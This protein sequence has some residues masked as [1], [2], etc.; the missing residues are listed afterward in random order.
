MHS[1]RELT[2]DVIVIG[3][4]A[5]GSASL[6]HLAKNNLRVLGLDKYHPPHD[7]GSTHGET[8]MIREAYYEDPTYVPLVQ[9]AYRLWDQLENETKQKLFRRTGMIM[10]GGPKSPYMQGIRTS[11]KLHKLPVEEL[12][13]EETMKRY[14]AVN[15]PQGLSAL[16][17]K[18]AGVL[19][20]EKCIEVMLQLA[21]NF[22]AEAKFN[23]ECKKW[24][25][26]AD[27]TFLV[28][29]EKGAYR[30][31]KIV[32][33]AGAWMPGLVPSNLASELK[34]ERKYFIWKKPYG[35]KENLSIN[36]FVCFMMDDPSGNVLYGFPDIGTGVKFGIHRASDGG[37]K[38]K[39]PEEINRT[40]G[41]E[42]AR[43]ALELL[44]KYLPD[45]KD[46]NSK[47]WTMDK[48]ATCM[49]TVTKDYHFV[50]DFL[51]GNK[52]IVVASPCSGHGFK[53][54]I[55]IGEVIKDLLTAG[56]SRFDLSLF[57]LSR[58][59]QKPKL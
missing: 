33:S 35:N 58:F 26:E 19:D 54:A 9:H 44:S 4:G 47:E 48:S 5:M 36:N 2:Y 51:Y 20:P 55:A 39:T 21:R 42:E 23:E 30:A 12:T 46:K 24:T 8:R 13:A 32:L 40:V 7:L 57:R 56:E 6:Y 11:A 53:F 17:E 22:G 45:L 15:V 16:Y 52:N 31:K 38:I 37:E 25:Q 18:N 1:K 14:P 27:G 29:T 43:D 3:L 41:I 34:V 50:L 49:Y 28:Q 59:A 10:I